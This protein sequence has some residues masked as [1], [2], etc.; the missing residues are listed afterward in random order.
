MESGK[1]ETVGGQR[2][3]CPVDKPAARAAHGN[4]DGGNV[5]NQVIG[6][7]NVDSVHKSQVSPIFIFVGM[8]AFVNKND[9]RSAKNSEEP[10]F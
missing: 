4:V 6:K 7:D 9:S 1:R 8:V 10:Q 2:S 3:R 5:D